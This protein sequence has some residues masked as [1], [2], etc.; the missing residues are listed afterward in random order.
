MIAQ[1]I[2]QFG[3]SRFLQAHVDLFVSQAI[4]RCDPNAGGICVVQS[5]ASTISTARVAALAGGEGYPVHIRGVR[6]GHSLDYGLNC[7]AIRAAVHA[8]SHWRQ[9]LDA[10]A[11]EVRV[12]VSNTGDR[13]F[14][15]DERDEATLLTQT[16]RAPRS[17]P[18]KLVVLLHH[19]W[20]ECPH[21]PLSLFPCEPVERNG[22]TLRDMV[23]RLAQQWRLP[24]SFVAWLWRHCVWANSVVDRMVGQALHPVGAV[25]E[26][27]AL[28]AIER[29]P[30]LVLPCSH[31]AIVLTDDLEKHERFKLFL[32]HAG[33]TYLAEL[34][35]ARS[36]PK[37]M[38]VLQAMNHREMRAE[39]EAMW[40]EEVVPIFQA[41]GQETAA[42]AYLV[43]LR[44]RLLNPF[45]E[46]R[47]ADIAENHAPKKVRRLGPILT[48]NSQLSL[49][50]PQ[51]RLR[52]ALISRV[53]AKPFAPVARRHSRGAGA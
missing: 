52:A 22:D 38:T 51:T 32:L 6:H 48:L 36:S 31:E 33:Q 14:R 12:I 47:L 42:L 5:T 53:E 19:R 1:A 10:I 46:H 21:A 35:L 9:L 41:L 8:D 49:Q 11:S 30:G 34:W 7:G 16:W 43:D 45:L 29:R 37:D 40:A 50:L 4:D 13:G 39:L 3:T 23:T 20:R 44:E 26:P 15:L 18:A 17:Y 24:G 27:Y 25:T 28:W 2:L